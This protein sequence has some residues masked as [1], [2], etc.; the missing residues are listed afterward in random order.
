MPF[1]HEIFDGVSETSYTLEK[2]D[3]AEDYPW[4]V[5]QFE[6]E[7]P[8][9]FGSIGFEAHANLKRL[10]PSTELLDVE[11]EVQ[12]VPKEFRMY[13]VVE[14]NKPMEIKDHLSYA[15]SRDN[16]LDKLNT[17]MS[18]TNRWDTAASKEK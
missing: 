12:K 7:N 11:H 8:V 17:L 1:P 6:Y 14:E 13:G 18:Q 5:I 16:R 2:G 15:D 10:D 4:L 9:Q 3:D